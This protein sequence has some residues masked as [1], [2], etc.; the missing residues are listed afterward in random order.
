MKMWKSSRDLQYST[1]PHTIRLKTKHISA[2]DPPRSSAPGALDYALFGAA[3]L[4]VLALLYAFN[5][6]AMGYGSV[7]IP[8]LKFAWTLW[9]IGED[10]QHC[11]FVPLAI[12]AMIYFERKNLPQRPLERSWAGLALT[13]FALFVYWVGFRA[14]NVYIGYASFQLL[15]GGL[16]LWLMGWTWAKALFIPWAFLVFLYPL[17]FLDNLVAFPLRLIMSEASVHF[18]NFIGIACIKSGTGILSAPDVMAGLRAG[19]KFSVDVADPCSG[20]RSLFALMM[21]SALYG[22]FTQK[23]F[24]KKGVIFLAS[25]PLAVAGNLARILMLTLGTIAMGP[26]V[27]I[28]TLEKPTFFHM[29]AGYLVFAVALGGMLFVGFL[30]NLPWADVCEGL[31]K[32]RDELRKSPPPRGSRPKHV[33]EY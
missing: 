31:K 8:I 11:Y 19:Q 3:G 12:G 29:L 10:W 4:V 15:T 22:Y 23:E 6:Y 25:I 27:A 17:T 33:D 16:I 32:S 20:I 7:P 30:V 5:P 13:V 18:L 28:G 26:E 1:A 14:D 2:I 21:V 9:G 24:W